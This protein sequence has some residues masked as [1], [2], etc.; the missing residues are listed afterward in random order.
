MTVFYCPRFEI[1]QTWSARPLN[2]YPQ[3]TGCPSYTPRHWVPFLSPP[4]TCRAMMEMFEPASTRGCNQ[5][6]WCPRY[7]ASGRPNRKHCLQQFFYC[8][9]G[10]LPSNSP[11]IV[12]MGTCLPG[13][14]QTMH[15][16]S[17]HHCIA[18]VL[19]LTIF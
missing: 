7:I 10:W 16:P 1:P 12:F 4:M 3:R 17:C 2:L 19:H 6:A 5:P 8:C 9:Y 13:P 18:K 11:D 14:Y 15:F